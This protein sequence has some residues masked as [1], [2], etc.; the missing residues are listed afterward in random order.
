MASGRVRSR[1]L[2]ESSIISL[3]SVLDSRPLWAGFSLRHSVLRV[4]KDQWLLPASVPSM[5]HHAEQVIVRQGLA[6]AFLPSA[7]CVKTHRDHPTPTADLVWPSLLAQAPLD[8]P[9]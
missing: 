5:H 7:P 6:P 3:P 4:Q 1:C 9:A 2:N 8:H